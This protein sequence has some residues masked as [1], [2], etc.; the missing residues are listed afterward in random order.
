MIKKQISLDILSTRN[1]KQLIFDHINRCTKLRLHPTA[2]YSMFSQDV[3]RGGNWT[4]N[5][6]RLLSRNLFRLQGRISTKTKN[7]ACNPWRLLERE[8]GY[9]TCDW[10]ERSPKLLRKLT[11][12]ANQSAHLLMKVFYDFKKSANVFRKGTKIPISEPIP[13]HRNCT[14]PYTT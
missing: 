11:T 13:T 4:S 6:F 2:P 10:T 3:N 14:S 12:L 1:G 7:D 8:R 5:L 9:A